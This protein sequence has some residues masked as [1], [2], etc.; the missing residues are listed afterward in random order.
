MTE[1][2]QPPCPLALQSFSV[3]LSL[4]PSSVAQNCTGNIVLAFFTPKT[5][6]PFPLPAQL[7]RVSLGPENKW[8]GKTGAMLGFFIQ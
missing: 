2:T 3:A 4:L 7:S 8:G 1:L 5:L 6:Q